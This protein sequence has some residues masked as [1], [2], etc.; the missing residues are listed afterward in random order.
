ML[1]L[2]IINMKCDISLFYLFEFIW[3]IENLRVYVFFVLWDYRIVF[4]FFVGG[5][6]EGRK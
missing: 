2:G 1:M 4:I 3:E 6:F 5:R